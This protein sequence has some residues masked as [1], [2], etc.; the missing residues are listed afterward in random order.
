MKTKFQRCVFVAACFAIALLALLLLRNHS[1]KTAGASALTNV[2]EFAKSRII[3]GVGVMLRADPAT[4]F[5]IV[6]GVFTNSPADK[7]GLRA[8]DVITTVNG[9]TMKGKPLAQVTD[10][11]R[12]LSIGSVT[13]G[14]QRNGSTNFECVIR[15]NS[16]HALTNQFPRPSGIKNYLIVTNANGSKRKIAR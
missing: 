13:L 12:G 15:R 1:L 4:G 16:W 9:A 8:G 2:V 10:S 7:A 11:I 6:Q 5:P 14:I 3:G